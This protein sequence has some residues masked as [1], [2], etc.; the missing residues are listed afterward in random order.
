MQERYKLVKNKHLCFCCLSDKHIVKRCKQN[1]SKCNGKH[2]LSLCRGNEDGDRAGNNVVGECAQDD[3]KPKGL[4]L[5][6]VNN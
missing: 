4:G 5:L 3:Q 6:S 1:C 2:H